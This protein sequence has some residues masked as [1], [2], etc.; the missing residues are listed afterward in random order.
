MSS[1]PST[2]LTPEPSQN[3]SDKT[4]I[5][6][7]RSTAGRPKRRDR[8]V[9]LRG[10]R[11]VQDQRK[12]ASLSGNRTVTDPPDIRENLLNYAEAADFLGVARAT[13]EVWVSTGR[14]SVPHLK[15][16]RLVKFRRT[17]LA[18]WLKSRERNVVIPQ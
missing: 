17:A 2:D 6:G 10:L 7:V 15:V 8:G 1:Q 18:Q 9:S 5:P 4:V 14:Y 16:G 12:G 13:L 11:I 3:L